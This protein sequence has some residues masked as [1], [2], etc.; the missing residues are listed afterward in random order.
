[1][2]DAY[3]NSITN[4]GYADEVAAIKA[5]NP[6]PHPARGEV[7]ASADH[8]LAQLAAYGSPEKARAMIAAWDDAVDINAIGIPPGLPWEQIEASI[9]AGAPD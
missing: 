9:R 5:A 1:M 2:G 7:P 8:L 3:A 4:Q 6:Q